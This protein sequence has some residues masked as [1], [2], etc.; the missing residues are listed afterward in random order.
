MRHNLPEKYNFKTLGSRA[1]RL[2]VEFDDRH[3]PIF[4]L[5]DVIDITGLTPRLVHS[6]IAKAEAARGALS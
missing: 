2:I 3:Q 5:A 4:S 6:L 1:A